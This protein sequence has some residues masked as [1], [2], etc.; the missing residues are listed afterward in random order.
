MRDAPLQLRTIGHLLADKALSAG[1]RTCLIWGD[2]RYT[3]AEMHALTNRYANG[4]AALGIGKS[5]HVALLLGNHQEFLF[6]AWGLGKIGAV[7]VPLNTAAKGDLLR[8]FLTQSDAKWLIVEDEFATRAADVVPA[9]A[10]L[11]GV[12]H[13]GA[14]APFASSGKR[15]VDFRA[16]PSVDDR[17]PPVDAVAFSDPAFI[18]Y[19]SGTTGPSKGVISPHAQGI[20]VGRY[21]ARQYGYASDDVL[22][23][24]LP[25]FHVNALWYSCNAALW[26]GGAIALA[27]RFSASGF[28]DDI[29]RTGATQFNALGVMASLLLKQP[30]TDAER[31]H[32][33]RQSMVVPLSK[34]SFKEY[35]ERF[36]LKVTS[37]FA[38][39]ETFAVTLYKPDEPAEKAASA[40]H[41]HGHADIRIVDDLD[42]SLPPG[43]VGEILVRPCE[44]WTGML[45][46]YKMPEATVEA[47]RNLWF[48]TGDRGFLDPDGYLWFVDRKKETIRRRGENISAYEVE[49]LI[50]KHPDVIEVAAVPVASELGEDD[51]M[52]YVVSR[53]GAALSETSLVEFC[54]ANMSYFMVPRYVAFIDALPK[55]ASEKIEKYKL[56]QMAAAD[57]S[58]LWDREKA[59][60]RLKR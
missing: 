45:G 27:P 30:L 26:V 6:A 44:P 40:G 37:L 39:T 36:R 12:I 54:A 20:N 15:L 4:F 31:R 1:S 34:Q 19:T 53:Q 60:I 55:T 2:R 59:G 33:V 41:P 22:Y 51:V 18:I 28:W 35:A 57:L 56:K 52:V 24:C 3:Y 43:T 38:A 42:Q 9:L 17:A 48:H 10:G 32:T 29:C 58:R 47:N 16:V 8:Y 46:Y 5:D 7:A 21:C 49:M 23:V 25:L 14:A 50:A 11:E 13:L